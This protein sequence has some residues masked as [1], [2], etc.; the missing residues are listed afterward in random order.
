MSDKEIMG[1]SQDSY[2]KTPQELLKA[3][4]I[5][6]I[7]RLAVLSCTELSVGRWEKKPIKIADSYQMSQ[8]YVEDQRKQFC[9]GTDFLLTL[10]H[11]E[12]KNDDKGGFENKLT[13][14]KTNLDT[15]KKTFKDKNKNT[16]I[17]ELKT[18]WLWIKLEHKKI[19]FTEIMLMLDVQDYFKSGAGGISI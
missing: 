14:L 10:V 12:Y 19:L 13:T 6:H 1:D 4:V 3:V 17:K 11:S 2:A 7:E 5:R 16:D 9:N 8:H 15:S 18:K